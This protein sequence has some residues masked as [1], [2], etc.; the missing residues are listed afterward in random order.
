MSDV[1]DPKT[2]KCRACGAEVYWAMSA[3]G[4]KMPVDAAVNDKGNILMQIDS[5][6]NLRFITVRGT[7]N[8]KRNRYTSHFATCP[9][10]AAFRK[11]R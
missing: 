5:E 10:A 7:A 3:N 9:Y 1:T 6:G 8:L 2:S 4:R 11:T